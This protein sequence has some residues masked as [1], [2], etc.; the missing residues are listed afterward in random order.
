M[1]KVATV[2]ANAMTPLV[3][4]TVNSAPCFNEKVDHDGFDENDDKE[5]RWVDVLMIILTVKIRCWW[6]S[7][8]RG[9]PDGAS[10]SYSVG[11]P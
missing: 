10:P 6:V 11:A 8:P 2:I 5:S 1:V 9:T 3:T 4:H 7:M